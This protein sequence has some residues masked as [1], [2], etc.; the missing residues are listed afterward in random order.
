MVSIATGDTSKEKINTYWT[1]KETWSLI[2]VFNNINCEFTKLR[3]WGDVESVLVEE[4]AVED[5][6]R[7]NAKLWRRN[8][9]IK[10]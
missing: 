5:K 10:I 7:R 9:E 2:W 1:N 8:I 6:K 4:T 3:V